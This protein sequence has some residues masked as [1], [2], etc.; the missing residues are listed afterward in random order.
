MA[1]KRVLLSGASGFIGRFAIAPLLARGYEVHAI[2]RRPL[3]VPA[4]RTH[5]VDL[6]DHATHEALLHRVRPSHL[7][8]VAWYAEH[9]KFWN[10]LENL[11]WLKATHALAE[12]FYATGGQRFVGVGSCAEYEWSQPVCSEAGT[13]EHPASLY[14][15]AKL[16]AGQ[17]LRVI[18]LAHSASHAWARL[19]FP[20]GPG[21]TATRLI[22]YVINSLL[23]G[24]EA[25]CTH[26]RQLRDY[27]H[28]A[29]I[30]DALAAIVDT[31][32]EDTI[33]VGSGEALSIANV[34]SRIGELLGR[35]E[36][37]RLGAIPEPEHS[38]QAV[39][40]DVARLRDEVGWRPRL[41]LSAGL[42]DTIRWWQAAGR[43]N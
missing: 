32:V 21:E 3:D 42:Q 17:S 15:A 43:E 16:A 33:N 4:V 20:Y 9:G 1:G 12:T 38:G 5:M 35:S 6:L 25:R 34:V 24:E 39:V 10:A 36:L 8:H 22:P 13:R 31:S 18:A 40:A 26:G 28:A 11:T 41:A 37:I 7:L 14:G 29:D 19:F 2:A 23:R 30:G 27:L